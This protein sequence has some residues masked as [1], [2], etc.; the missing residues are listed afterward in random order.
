MGKAM[1]SMRVRKVDH[2]K[3][4]PAVALMPAGRDTAPSREREEAPGGLLY[5]LGLPES[6]HRER[7]DPNMFRVVR[8]LGAVS[9]SSLLAVLLGLTAL[10]AKA[11][12]SAPAVD[13]KKGQA[14][15]SQ[16]CAACHGAD[17]NSPTPAN[18]KLAGQHADYLYKQLKNFKPK[19]D[20]KEAERVNAVMAA[21]AAQLSDADMRNVAAFYAS[22]K[23]IPSTAKDKTTVEKGRNIYRAGIA[24]KG[25]PSCAGC[26]SPNGAGI[27]A[28]YPR[29]QGQYAEYTEAQLIAFRKGERNNSAM[30]SAIA[31]RMSDAEIKAVSDYIAGLR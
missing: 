3:P 5:N 15:A 13:L 21:F 6:S 27:P 28:Q 24:A 14:I 11:Q 18:P 20:A 31:S 25:V 30:M 17:G 22:Q 1:G 29:L 8:A 7:L 10:A 23:L 9:L 16:V 19:P 4:K 26:H 2:D 12:G